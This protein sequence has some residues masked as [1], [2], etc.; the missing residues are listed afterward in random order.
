MTA[1][2]LAEIIVSGKQ[3]DEI[4]TQGAALEEVMQ[5]YAST[6]ND[7]KCYLRILKSMVERLRH[8]EENG[9]E[10]PAPAADNIVEADDDEEELK[11]RSSSISE[12]AKKKSKK[13]K[14][15]QVKREQSEVSAVSNAPSEATTATSIDAEKKVDPLVTA[16]LGMGFTEEQIHA[17]AKACG[18]MERATA[19]E[20]VMW[21][22]GGG[23]QQASSPQPATARSEEP[24]TE[25]AFVSTGKSRTNTKQAPLKKSSQKAAAAN[26]KRAQKE[27]MQAVKRGDEARA[28]AD[29]LAAKREEQRRR[30]REWNNR[31]QARQKE[32]MELRAQEEARRIANEKAAAQRHAAMLAGKAHGVPVQTRSA[33]A[34]P[35]APTQILQRPAHMPVGGLQAGMMPVRP[36]GEYDG[37]A[38]YVSSGNSV[39]SAGSGMNAAVAAQY[40][41]SGNSVSSAGSGMNPMAAQY[42]SSA[43]SVSSHG[44]G[45]HHQQAYYGY[46]NAGV[47][48]PGFNSFGGTPV[49]SVGSTSL[50]M[51]EETPVSYEENASGEIRATARSFVPTAFN[52]ATASSSA[53]TPVSSSAPA[54]PPPV[55][56]GMGL[57]PTPEQSQ[58]STLSNDDPL[59]SLLSAAAPGT[60][61]PVIGSSP[62]LEATAEEPSLNAVLGLNLTGA[63]NGSSLL[64]SLSMPPPANVG[65]ESATAG[66]WGGTSLA[67][68]P[69]SS[70]S[71]FGVP[72]IDSSS[73]HENTSGGDGG[74]GLWNSGVS[75]NRGGTSR[76]GSIW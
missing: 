46:P 51:S 15:K 41:S 58:S 64:D 16:L 65:T 74:S 57:S 35:P 32:E 31:A 14:K 22:L 9:Y 19:D 59:A 40:V 54:P 76:L 27:N 25:E 29:R 34:Q 39:S 69:S 60:A 8:V 30:N 70:L 20:M 4:E 50:G 53:S 52:P 2:E 13:K 71:G 24:S 23:E 72:G 67:P 28:A 17:A 21:I 61:A 48:P 66:I 56:P 26:L 10:P 36:Y 1:S 11:Q 49:P 5:R 47:P 33:Q 38:Q 73:N 37:M 6:K 42:V 18:G 44:S 43:N 68:A 12:D 7:K 55:P 62:A 75:S 45:M 63:S 3:H